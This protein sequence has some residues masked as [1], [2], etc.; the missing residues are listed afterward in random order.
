M[1]KIIYIGMLMLAVMFTACSE[2]ND[3]HQH[4]LDEGER[5]YAAK[6]DSVLTKP[7]KLRLALDIFLPSQRAE[8]GMIYWNNNQD[9]LEFEVERTQDE[10]Q[11]IIIA[12]LQEGSHIFTFM[13][14]DSFGNS[15][16]PYEAVGTVYGEDYA[17][18]LLNRGIE[19]VVK[20]GNDMLI[21]W[22]ESGESAG[23]LL[24]YTNKSGETMNVEIPSYETETV[25]SD[26]NSGDEFSYI[27]Y[28]LPVDEAIDVFPTVP[29]SGRFPY[30]KWEDRSGWEVIACSDEREDDGGGKSAVLDGNMD[31]YWHSQWGPDM[32]L[33]HWVLI[34][35]KKSYE[36]GGIEIARRLNNTDTKALKFE[37]SEDGTNFVEMGTMDFGGTSN[38]ENSK[39]VTFSVVQGRYL[40]CWVTESNSEPHSSIAEIYI[41]GREAR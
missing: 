5:V 15:S 2:M 38:T 9:S 18:S 27:T 37:I 4:Y 12:D 3:L 13:M 7:G 6:V 41:L 25:V 10:F 23:V 30:E 26:V 11:R 22:K 34:D 35:M 40:K 24:T 8:K 20:S 31:T 14:Y 1:K 29:K 19:E 32:P 33:P 36:V 28:Y 39:T 17:N 21:R 16:L